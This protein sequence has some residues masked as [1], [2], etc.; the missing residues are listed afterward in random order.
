[1]DLGGV[2]KERKLGL[3]L[4]WLDGFV[5]HQQRDKA[6]AGRVQSKSNRESEYGTCCVWMTCDSLLEESSRKM[7]IWVWSKK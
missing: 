6:E 4:F 3:L 7:D 1:M 5:I 2:R